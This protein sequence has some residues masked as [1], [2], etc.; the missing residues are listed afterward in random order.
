MPLELATI[1]CRT[2]NYAF[3]LNDADSGRT[4]LIDAPETQPILTALESR[5]W[6]LDEVWITH[7]HGDHVEGLPG[8]RASFPGVH[9]TGAAADAGRLPPLDRGVAGGE[10]F[11]FAAHAVEVLDV[12][13]HTLGHIAFYVPAAKAAFTADSLMAMGCGRLFEGTSEMMWNSLRRLM[14]LPDDT[15]I[16]SGHEYTAANARFAESVDIGNPALADR[17][18][19]IAAARA[20]GQP[21]VPSALGLEKATNPFLQAVTDRMKAALGMP[22]ATD[23]EVFAE[24]RRRKDA[25]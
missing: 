3:L 21:T 7:H 20:A 2:D 4:A 9:V 22:D 18:A 17:A 1:P 10:T 8:L 6:T 16:C 5:G 14:S 13:G 15:L 24:L 19:A 25:F 11:A 12:P 23:I